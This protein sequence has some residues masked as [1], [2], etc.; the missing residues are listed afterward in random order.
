[1][2]A[3]AGLDWVL[4]GSRD[5][6]GLT[7]S[8]GSSALEDFSSQWKDPQVADE[9]RAIGVENPAQLG[10]L[11][12]AD[13]DDLKRVTR[14]V[15]PVVDTFPYRI[16]LP[17][18]ASR[19]VPPLYAWMMDTTRAAQ[20]FADSGFIRHHWPAELIADTLPYFPSQR[21]INQRYAPGLDK[22]A[23]YTIDRLRQVLVD[24]DLESLPL[25]MMGSNYFEQRLLDS[26]A[27]DPQYTQAYEWG[28]ARRD[29]AERRYTEAMQRLERIRAETDPANRVR[30][31]QLYSLA[32]S[33]KDY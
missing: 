16:L 30:L 1:L 20:S 19:Q 21:L 4:L 31:D 23:P 10:S 14:D 6:P 24:T 13:A 7:G 18:S 5:A 26:V 11:F 28:L 32:D 2:W 15:Q 17:Y 3:G 12:M 27:T 9:L 22:P 29:I 33:L 25:W 8:S